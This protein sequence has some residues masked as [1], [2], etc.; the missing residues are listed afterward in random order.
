MENE[1]TGVKSSGEQI[2]LFIQKYRVALFV[3]IGL[4]CAGVVGSAGFFSI[5]DSMQRKA[6]TTMEGFEK[7][8]ADMGE[9]QDAPDTPELDALLEE[10]IAF[11]PSTFG[12][13]AAKSYSIAADIYAARGK[14]EM[15]EEAW[16]L[17]AR[18]G[19]KTYMAPV[20]LFNAAVAA[21]E[22]GKPEKA[23]DYYSQSLAFKGIF[24]GASR[25]R[26]NIGRIHEE[27]QDKEAAKEAYRTLIEKSSADSGWTKL[28]QSRIIALELE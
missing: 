14:W 19:A 5:R 18:K 8:K 16:V 7:R 6:I 11:A 22:Q 15:A 9:I 10:V 13:A 23:L 3:F 25:A 2:T 21:E 4:L 24:A 28:A 20:S 12:Y 26:F 17:S 27:R 1:K